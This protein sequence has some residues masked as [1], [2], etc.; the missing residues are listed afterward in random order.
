MKV[1]RMVLNF[2]IDEKERIWFLFCSSLRLKNPSSVLHKY[3]GPILSKIVYEN[4]QI[5][6]NAI[7]FFIKIN[8]FFV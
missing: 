1:D 8:N 2:K 6:I 7:I 4:P 5:E 3:Y